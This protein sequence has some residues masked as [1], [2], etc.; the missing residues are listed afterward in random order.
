MNEKLEHQVE[1]KPII[2]CLGTVDDYGIDKLNPVPNEF[3]INQAH[4]IDWASSKKE[5]MKNRF[6]NAGE[7][8]YVISPI[9]N[10][11]KF[12]K[13]LSRCTGLIIAG[14]DKKTGENISFLSH[15]DPYALFINLK[16]DN[17]VKHLNQRLLEM[18]NRCRQSSVSSVIVGGR[19]YGETHPEID[20]VLESYPDIVKLIDLEVKKVLGIETV[21]ANGP[22]IPRGFDDIY[23][24]NKNRRLYLIRP[25]INSD[26][27]SFPASDV[28]NQK[29]K[30]E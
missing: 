3:D 10:S 22:K 27:G 24:D 5:L 19:Y 14:T 15:Q 26:T 29:N 30:W 17:F 25:R 21:V 4:N 20:Y 8:T 13:E 18:K 7:R 11:D 23:Y 16:K 2:V 12:S 6:L 1:G 28:D 9:D